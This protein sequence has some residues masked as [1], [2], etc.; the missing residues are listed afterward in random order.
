[1]TIFKSV[2]IAL[3]DLVAADIAYRKAIELGI[4]LQV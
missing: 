2:G 3:E 4:G 1:M